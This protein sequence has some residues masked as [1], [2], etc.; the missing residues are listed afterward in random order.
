MNTFYPTRKLNL[1]ESIPMCLGCTFCGQ[2]I[3]KSYCKKATRGRW[4]AAEDVK[5]CSKFKKRKIP[6]D[7]IHLEN[8]EVRDI[9]LNAMSTCAC[10][11]INDKVSPQ[12]S[13]ALQ[14]LKEERPA[15]DSEEKEMSEITLTAQAGRK[16]VTQ[17][18]DAI[19]EGLE[20]LK[21]G[22]SITKDFFDA[23]SK[24]HKQAEEIFDEKF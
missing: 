5:N 23:V 22:D 1:S 16:E 15:L 2:Y 7:P 20:K 18:V 13:G 4:W 3:N 9:L 19:I 11:L 10:T 21:E 14:K 6:E 12:S 24:A 17:A 8:S